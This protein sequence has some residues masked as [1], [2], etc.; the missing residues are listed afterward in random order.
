MW[1]MPGKAHMSFIVA[2]EVAMPACGLFII[3]EA[4]AAPPIIM[5]VAG[6]GD[7]AAGVIATDSMALA[8]GMTSCDIVDEVDAVLEIMPLMPD[9][10]AILTFAVVTA[11]FLARRGG[12]SCQWYSQKRVILQ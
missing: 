4:I 9:M 5:L 3:D 10:A 7:L 8:V 6:V 1:L 12:F 2:I 11:Q